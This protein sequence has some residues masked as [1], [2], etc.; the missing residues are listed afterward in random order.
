MRS[1]FTPLVLLSLA[2]CTESSEPSSP[3]DPETSPATRP[4]FVIAMENHDAA[5]IYGNTSAAPYINGTLLERYA[6]AVSFNDALPDLVSQPHYI[7]IEAGT[8]ALPDHTFKN[9]DV[10]S[11]T[12]STD[13]VEHL[14]TQIAASKELTWRS[15]QEGIDEGSGRCP[16]AKSGFYHPKHNPFVYFQ[17]VSG[18]PPSKDNAYCAEHH[19]ELG[20]LADDMERGEVASYN[21]IT[22]NQCNDMHGQTGCP[23]SDTVRAGDAWL[24]RTLPALITF[25]DAYDGVLFLTWDEGHKKDLIPFVAIGPH[26]KRG[27]ASSAAIDHRSLLKSIERLLGLPVLPTVEA[28]STLS[29]MFEP[30]EFP[31]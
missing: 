8:N 26:V 11:A 25:L 24:E 12:N 30:G 5:E 18:S 22:P 29:D 14:V 31:D 20:A 4:V 2:A 3:Q 7:M 15:Y 28:A 16:I 21:F 27:Y 9:D 19:R 23:E 13:S 1:L 6:H 10:P 17:D